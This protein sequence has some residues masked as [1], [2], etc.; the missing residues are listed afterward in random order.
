[1]IFYHPT[2]KEEAELILEEH[3]FNPQSKE[4]AIDELEVIKWYRDFLCEGER[5]FVNRV[6]EEW[7][8]S[9][10]LNHVM[11]ANAIIHSCKIKSLLEPLKKCLENFKKCGTP[12]HRLYCK[13]LEETI[14]KISQ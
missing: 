7:L 6:L 11:T 8:Q 14:Q 4:G 5:S 13:S 2:S 12:L 3:L 9:E 10:D 1:M